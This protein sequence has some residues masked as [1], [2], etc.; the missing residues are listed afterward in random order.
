MTIMASLGR[1]DVDVRSWNVIFAPRGIVKDVLVFSRKSLAAP[2]VGPELRAQMAV[3]GVK[4]STSESVDPGI[5]S[6]VIT[7][8]LSRN[9]LALRV[10]SEYLN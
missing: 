4:L 2:G 7:L 3:V 1:S 9:V 6:A 5:D 8:G 10:R